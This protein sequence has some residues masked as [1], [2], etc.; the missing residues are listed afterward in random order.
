MSFEK[1]FEVIAN[2]LPAEGV[3]FLMI[4]GHAVSV[5][6]YVRATIDVDF[7]IAAED[8]ATVRKVMKSAGFSNVSAGENVIFFS[9]PDSVLRIDFL[10]VDTATMRELLSRASSVEYAGS[11]LRIPGL[12]DLIAMKL[13]A[14]HNGPAKRERRD[15]ED[16]VQLVLEHGWNVEA[17][18]KPLC[19][20]FADQALYNK[21]ATRIEGERLA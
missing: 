9:Q 5:Y 21:L 4:G 11:S 10:P 1:T 6:G 15:S 2:Q 18:L 17:Q 16:V 13:F 20:R 7:M 3:D 14:L 19:L 8:V 12:E